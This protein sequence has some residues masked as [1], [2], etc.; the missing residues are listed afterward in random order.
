V[1]IQ[2]HRLLERTVEDSNLSLNSS[3]IGGKNRDG[4]KGIDALQRNGF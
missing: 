3:E 4:T 1:A 2:Q